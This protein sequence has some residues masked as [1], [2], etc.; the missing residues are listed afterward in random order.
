[1]SRLRLVPILI[2]L[3]ITLAVL[4]GGWQ[5]YRH[6]NLIAPLQ[7][8]LE[9]IQGV[10]SANVASGNSNTVVVKLGKVQDLQSTYDRISSAITA[11]SGSAVNI[12]IE[13]NRTPALIAEYEQLQPIL[14]QGLAQGTYTTMIRD[15][16]AAAQK[17]GFATRVTMDDQHVFVQLEKNGHYLYNVQSYTLRQGAGSA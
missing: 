16:E 4:F 12:E 10:Q 7:T 15:V 6:Y 3:V 11:A 2:I 13:D 5:A 1:M 9:K 14:F 17:A 8:T